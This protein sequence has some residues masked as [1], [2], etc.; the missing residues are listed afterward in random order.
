MLPIVEVPGLAWSIKSYNLLLVLAVG[1]SSVLAH[2]WIVESGEDSRRTWWALGLFWLLAFLGGRINYVV[3]HWSMYRSLGLDVVLLRLQTHTPGILVGA[4]IGIFAV[5]PALG[6]RS[7]AFLDGLAMAAGVAFAIARLG[8]FLNGCCAGGVCDLPWAVSFP[9]ASPVFTTQREMGMRVGNLAA[10]IP[11]H[12]LQLYF[13]IVGLV[14]SAV[15]VMVR[16]HKRYEGQLGLL[17][18]L[19]F[20]G[21][22]TVL[23]TLRFELPK[24]GQ[25]EVSTYLF[26]SHLAL[27][28]TTLSIWVLVEV[29]RHRNKLEL[30]DCTSSN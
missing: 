8:C 6:V 29:M 27:F 18:L 26:W 1:V 11:V 10:S 15:L 14:I 25:G 19:L 21:S 5:V 16:R 30:P 12:P 22:S 9:A 7:V 24:P 2:R 28:T 13:A 4:V 23:E 3:A 17:F 20:S